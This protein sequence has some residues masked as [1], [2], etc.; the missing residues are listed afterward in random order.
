MDFMGSLEKSLL[1][2]TNSACEEGNGLTTAQMKDIFKL[3]I[4]AIRHTQRIN[5]TLCQG[6]WHSDSWR[7][8]SG[9]LAASRF[10]S[11]PAL[12]N[13]CEQ[14]IKLAQATPP[15]KSSTGTDL[16]AHDSVKRKAVTVPEEDTTVQVKK[17]KR[18]KSKR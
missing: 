2:A 13:M 3:G 10:K 5:S 12:Q 15:S 11:S 7:V 9:R 8:L 4:V 1:M 16:R 17:P 6:I 14:L 18:T